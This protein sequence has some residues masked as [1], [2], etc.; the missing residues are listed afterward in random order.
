SKTCCFLL[1]D[2]TLR[3]R[4][5]IIHKTATNAI[6][7]HVITVDSEISRPPKMGI[8]KTVLQLSSSSKVSPRFSVQSLP[9]WKNLIRSEEHTSELQSRFDLV[10]RLLLEK[11]KKYKK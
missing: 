1:G 3:L 4:T 2:S 10:C 11:K 9:F 7:N 8:V 5:S 6:I